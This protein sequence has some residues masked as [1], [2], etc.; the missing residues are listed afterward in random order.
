MTVGNE[1]EA[2]LV[3]RA[4]IL[5]GTLAANAPTVR[6]AA[7]TATAAFIVDEVAESE[8]EELFVE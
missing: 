1:V 5:F 7:A 8:D 2:V 6:A 3:A 4:S